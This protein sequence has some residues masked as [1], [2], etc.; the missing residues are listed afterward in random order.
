[1][2]NEE[3]RRAKD[4]LY[5]LSQDEKER[6]LYFIREKSIKDEASALYN[7]EQKG[8]EK[9]I[10]K[11]KIDMIKKLSIVGMSIE[12]IAEIVSLSVEEVIEILNSL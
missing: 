11:T 1:M 7:A 10:Q 2:N 12:Q 5:K 4:K 3:I 6:E 8:I 9:G